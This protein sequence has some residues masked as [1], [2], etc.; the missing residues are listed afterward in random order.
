MN[1]IVLEKIILDDIY[2]RKMK[3]LIHTKPY[4]N[5]DDNFIHNHA[6]SKTTLMPTD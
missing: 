3:T 5:V 6:N 1:K 4:V 2:L